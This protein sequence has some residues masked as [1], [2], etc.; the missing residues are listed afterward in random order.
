[1]ACGGGVENG[2]VHSV[3]N[4]VENRRR[5]NPR[6]QGNRLS[7]LQIYLNSVFIGKVS[8]YSYQSFDIVV[9]ACNMMSSTHIKPFYF[10]EEITEFFFDSLS[11][12]LQC[13]GILFAERM[14]MQ[15]FYTFGKSVK[16]AFY[17]A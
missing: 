1:M 12:F 8:H 13:I 5:K 4:Y 9:W 10:R 16:A 6:V 17:C 3:V 7:R 15:S 2:Y 14:E 11:R